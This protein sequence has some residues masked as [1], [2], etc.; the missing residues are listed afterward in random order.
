[1]WRCCL[2]STTGRFIR[3]DTYDDQYFWA[4]N[5]R[6]R[7]KDAAAVIVHL[8]SHIICDVWLFKARKEALLNKT[9]SMPEIV[10]LYKSGS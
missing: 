1:M 8:A 7:F 10:D 2:L 3:A 5:C 4:T 6:R 9:L